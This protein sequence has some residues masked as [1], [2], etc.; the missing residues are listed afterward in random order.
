MNEN[1]QQQTPVI[2][3]WLDN[4]SSQL[5]AIGIK[6]AR[7]DAEIILDHTIRKNRTYLHAHGDEILN[8]RAREIADA[9]LALRLDRIPIAY[10]IGHKE[11]YGRRFKVT[12]A[13]LIPR[14]ES[15]TIIT[16]L[17]DIIPNNRSLLPNQKIRLVDVG[18]GCGILGITAKLEHPEIDVTM[19]DISLPALRVAENNAQILNA[20]VNT[21]K[22]DLLENYPFT[23]NIIIANLPY[24][25][26]SWERSLETDKEPE[27]A[28]FASNGGL[29]IINKLIVQASTQLVPH[30]SL[31]LEA[32]PYQHP[33]IIKFARRHGLQKSHQ[34]DY[35]I[36]FEKSD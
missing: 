10:I 29:S 5:E 27:I 8:E 13:T 30:G 21:I 35:C 7:L 3:D 22:S 4:A 12:T 14:P 11:F 20:T 19:V 24:V 1:S 23:P 9:R 17:N 2:K 6:S 33:K 36:A 15:E 34:Q 31:I 32:D 18:T 28:L 16:I 25:D 26:T